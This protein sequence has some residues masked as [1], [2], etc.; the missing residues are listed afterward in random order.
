MNKLILFL[1]IGTVLME[2]VM[3]FCRR[4][5]AFPVWKTALA[6][7]ILTAAGVAGVKILFF[8]E[9]GN[10]SGLSFYGAVLLVPV[11]FILVAKVLR[12]PYGE[13]M[14]VC[15]P[16]EAA[17]L[18]V[19]KIQCELTGCCGGRFLYLNKAGNLVYFPSRMVELWNAVVIMVVLMFL[20]RKTKNRGKIYPLFLLIYGVSR[21]ILNWFRNTSP[22]I[23]ILPAGNFWSLVAIGIGAVWL[24]MLKKKSE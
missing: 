20:M 4:W 14:D 15:A 13:L 1:L 21:F 12:L 23:W 11:I 10:W 6:A 22:F 18:I 16:S 8:I 2:A 3:F 9:N 24:A 7:P 19:M 17:M 5:Y